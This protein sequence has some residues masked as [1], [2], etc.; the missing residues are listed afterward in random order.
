MTDFERNKEELRRLLDINVQY[1]LLGAGVSF[2][3]NIPLMYQL[4]YRV[5]KMLRDNDKDIYSKIIEQLPDNCHVEHVLTHLGDL[6]AISR[7]VKSGEALVGEINYPR[8]ALETLYKSI[9]ECIGTTVRYG[10]RK[11]DGGDGDLVGEPGNSIVKIEPHLDFVD[12]VF[13]SRQNLES[14]TNISFFTT[15]YDT[16]LE[17]ALSLKKKIPADGF[18]GSAIGFWN[19]SSIESHDSSKI[20]QYCPL[21]K[22]HGS[23]DWVVD[24]EFGLVR[25]R[26]DVDYLSSKTNLLIYPQSTK[27]IET[28]KDPFA[29]LFGKLRSSLSSSTSHLLAVAGY[30]FG[31]NHI[32]NEIEFALRLQ[33]SKTNLIA[34]SKEVQD[35]AGNPALPETLE[36]WRQD[37]KMGRRIYI[38]SD[39]ALYWGENQY[40][41]EDN[42]I[43]NWWSFA[44]LTNFLRSGEA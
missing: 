32:N 20:T 26:Y 19:P 39:K 21:Y 10:Y 8:D 31:D 15:N 41:P 16:L 38:A 33:N 12:A 25:C 18:S 22:L 9:V 4:T 44:G 1:W 43:L 5:G 11:I 34:F 35:E 42:R 3:S 6:I 23:V 29:F 36:R 17:D 2:E 7:R 40:K 13:G 28:Q 14:R 24:E 27:Y 30:S 37:A